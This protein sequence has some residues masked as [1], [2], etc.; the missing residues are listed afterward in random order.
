MDLINI[1][2]D[3]RKLLG[4]KIKQLRSQGIVPAN[5]FGKKINSQ[6][7]SVD[8]KEFINIYQKVGETGVVNILLDKKTNPVL[9]HNVQKH[10]VTDQ[11]L[12]VDFFQV[13]LKQ[14]VTANVPVD[15]EGESPAEKQGLGTVVQQ[16]NEIEVEAL[17]MDLPDHVKVNIS[18]LENVDQAIYIKDLVYDKKKVEVKADP[19]QIVVKVEPLE[20]I[21]EPVAPTPAEGEAVV[22]GDEEKA[23]VEGKTE[24]PEK[25][26]EEVG[27]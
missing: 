23:A 20:K 19:E 14:K 25:P 1:K 21:E 10:P 16:V 6:A 5:I 22:E 7:I 24:T 12:H 11:I 13:D 8:L 27:K 15:L 3:N 17:P 4:R 26:Q 9:I 2:A 18:S